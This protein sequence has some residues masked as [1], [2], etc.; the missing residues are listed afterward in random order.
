M[1][2]N[3]IRCSITD[4]SPATARILP[5]VYLSRAA[6]SLYDAQYPP[7]AT[8][9]VP[10]PKETIKSVINALLHFKLTCADFGVPE[11]HV[12]VVATEATRK[13]IN[14]A[15]F[16]AE[17]LDKTGWNVELL[18]KEVEGRVGA[19]GVASSFA[20]VKG[21]VMDLGGGSTQITWVRTQDGR[22]DMYEKGS[23]S[24]PYGAAAL[25]K[26]LQ[27]AGASRQSE[28]FAIFE[29]Q[30]IGDL[31]A[32]V[33]T[34]DIP[35]DLI[36]QE[37]GLSLYVSG[38]GF[39]GWG[40]LLM[41]QHH[42]TPYPIPIINGF[43]TSVE[44]FHN[45]QTVKAA[46]NGEET[47][48][49]F[50]V[51]QR[52][53]GQVPAV[54]FL[55][56]CLAKTL[57]SVTNVYFCQGGVREGT[58]FSNLDASQR[59]ED[60]LVTATKPYAQHPIQGIVELLLEVAQGSL[61][62][63]RE[64]IFSLALVTA[65]AQAMYVHAA[66][67]KDLSAGAALRST[68]TGFFAAAHGISHEQRALLAILLCERYGGFGSISPTEQDFYHRM[69]QLLPDGTFWRCLV[70]GR[71]AGVL[72]KVHPAGVGSEKRVKLDT[73]WET[74]KKG[75]EKLCID[76]GFTQKI[77][78]LDEALHGA[79][80]KVGKAGKKKHWQGAEGH[81]VQVTVNGKEYSE[82]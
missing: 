54:A 64:T 33:K 6:I 17:I 48:D 19:H 68:T 1:L 39:R 43:R 74:T 63:P 81:K 78:E 72:A 69:M 34:I 51:S 56:D 32:A 53:A 79:L 14:S 26:G 57:P 73:R 45:T 22:I 3:G 28:A 9:P 24:L 11:H 23:V 42:I 41:S 62:G 82:E 15:E 30:V 47:P 20:D 16:R 50:R 2:C 35:R 29:K 40:F 25:M 21:L 70:F 77:D 49:I 75:N 5:T 52:R 13:A 18:E 12:R 27:T 46:V 36:E 58:H 4:L 65:F 55:V 38:G 44:S 66:F 71:I 59:L 60:P 7:N 67:P 31:T 76:F 61:S 8:A 80:L 10:I 37:G